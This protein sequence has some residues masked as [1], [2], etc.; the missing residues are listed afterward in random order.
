MASRHQRI[1]RVFV[2]GLVCLGAIRSSGAAP[3]T[4]PPDIRWVPEMERVTELQD[5]PPA[6][7]KDHA[8]ER[9]RL[10]EAW[11]EVREAVEREL[12]AAKVTPNPPSA[13]HPGHA[14]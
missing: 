12:T 1:L 2:C 3:E 8:R 9:Q 13:P 6:A 4:A 5:W 7:A 10:L 14:A 11:K